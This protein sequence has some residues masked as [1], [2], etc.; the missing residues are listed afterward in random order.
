M[1]GPRLRGSSTETCGR[2]LPLLVKVHAVAETS[3]W[4]FVSRCSSACTAAAFW[5]ETSRRTSFKVSVS[6]LRS[7]MAA[8]SW[9]RK[10][11]SSSELCWHASLSTPSSSRLRFNSTCV[12]R[13]S[14][15]AASKSSLVRF[16]STSIRCNCCVLSSSC[17]KSRPRAA[18]ISSHSRRTCVRQA[19][20]SIVVGV[21]ARDPEPRLLLC[22]T[23]SVVGIVRGFCRGRGT[24]AAPARRHR[25][26]AAQQHSLDTSA[27]P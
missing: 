25:R 9:L 11:A 18:S 1:L 6:C 27:W 4:H 15:P 26:A 16:T 20:A 13:S 24:A 22:A 21:S 8:W 2:E 17:R 12:V 7:S 23:A 5:P 3:S 19:V 14:S 10:D